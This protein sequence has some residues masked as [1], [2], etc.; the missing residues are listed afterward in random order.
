[1]FKDRNG[2]TN[3]V[4]NKTSAIGIPFTFYFGMTNINVT[5][6]LLDA[7]SCYSVIIGLCNYAYNHKCVVIFADNYIRTMFY[8]LSLLICIFNQQLLPYTMLHG[9]E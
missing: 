4:Y 9:E 2:L 5:V 6:C 1:M 8:S 7:S 3:G